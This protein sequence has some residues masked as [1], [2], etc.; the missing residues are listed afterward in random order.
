VIGSTEPRL[1]TRPL[2]ELTPATSYGFDVIEFARDVLRRPLDPWQEWLAIHAGE[3]LPDGRPRFRRVL[4]LV[5]RQNGKT[6]LLAVLAAYWLFIEC[7]GLVLGTSTKLPYAR[8]AWDKTRR[9]VEATPELADLRARRWTRRTNGEVEAWTLPDPDTGEV[10]R[11]LIAA[12]NEEAG[13]SLTIARLILDELRQH[14]GYDTW[15][16]AYNATRA[17]MDAQAWAITNAGSHRSVVLNDLRQEAIEGGDPELGHFEWS[18]PADADVR[19]VAALAAANPNLGRR[20]RTDSLVTEAEAALRAGGERLAG[21]KTES[22]CIT[23]AVLDPAIDPGAWGTCLDPGTLDAVRN[24]VAMCVD[25]AP[26]G[27]HVTLAAAAVL[28]D[29]RARVEVVEA[30]A[31]VGAADRAGR[32][33]G[34]LVRRARPRVLGWLPNGPAAELAA[35]LGGPGWPRHVPLEEIR[36]EVPAACMALRS[37]VLA[38]R[39][40]HSGD[41]LLNAHVEAAERFEVGDRWVFGRRGRGHVDAVYAAA[42]AVQLARSLPPPVGRPRI[43]LVTGE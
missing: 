43:V 20:I 23:V 10:S 5:A 28:D 8:E 30:W 39:L 29:G 25:V 17:V 6:H 3:L 33:L 14:H 40:A 32:E 9:M 35:S 24:R 22:L 18:G 37:V 11:Y 16:A 13:R 26:D 36:A 15:D 27:Q 38:R 19:D 12:A 21:F 41:P 2:R 31:G 1:W 42:G 4:V 7:V 34:A